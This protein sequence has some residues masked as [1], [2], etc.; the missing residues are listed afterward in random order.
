[1]RAL[2]LLIPIFV[3]YPLALADESIEICDSYAGVAEAAMEQRQRN[4]PLTEVMKAADYVYGQP[5]D[6]VQQLV[7]DAY[8]QPRFNTKKN[9]SKAVS[10]FRRKV[11]VACFKRQI[12]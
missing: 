11:E 3:I 7:I 8:E 4:T 9:Q 1:M 5:L 12:Q 6:F 2:F 10:E